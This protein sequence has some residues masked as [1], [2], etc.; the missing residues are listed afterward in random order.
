[1]TLLLD[2]DVLVD[3]LRGWPPA[4]RWLSE[5]SS[6]PFL[7]PGLVAMELSYG[8][9]NQRELDRTRRLLDRFAITWPTPEDGLLAFELLNRHRLSSGLSIP[10][11]YIAAQALNR[12]ARLH[13][14]NQKHFACILGLD[15]QPPYAR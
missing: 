4:E 11:C 1:M 12:S 8:C 2:T 9:P 7:I 6:Q 15:V 10:D 3:C 14:F 13:S 5:N